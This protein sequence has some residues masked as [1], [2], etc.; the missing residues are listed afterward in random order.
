MINKKN[1]NKYKRSFYYMM[2]GG[3]IPVETFFVSEVS[4][5]EVEVVNGILCF[6]GDITQIFTKLNKTTKEPVLYFRE[7]RLW[8]EE[9]IS[10]GRMLVEY[11]DYNYTKSIKVLENEEFKNLVAG[12]YVV[13]MENSRELVIFDED[14][15]K[16]CEVKFLL[17]NEKSFI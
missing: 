6:Y 9:A 15:L 7:P 12:D 8:I 14:T 4:K 2:R 10:E 5:E 3:A 17:R 13:C 16:T 1:P 11:D